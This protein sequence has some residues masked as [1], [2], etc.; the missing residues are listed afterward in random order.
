MVKTGDECVLVPPFARPDGE[1]IEIALN[2]TARLPRLSDMGDSLAYLYVNGITL[3]RVLLEEARH[4]VRQFGASLDKNEIVINI[5]E[6]KPAGDALHSLVQA[7]IGVTCLVQKRRPQTH[8]RFDEE[9]E[10]LIISQGRTYDVDYRIPGA[11]QTH[12]VRFHV[13]SGRR[14]LIQPLT[15][16]NETVAFSWA[17]R[18]AYRFGDI[19]KRDSTWNLFAVLDDRGER[20]SAWT[21]LVLTPLEGLAAIVPWGDSGRL[22][23]ALASSGR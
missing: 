1:Y 3:S 23:E 7:A 16:S 12:L 17:K 20:R 13:D 11:K 6:S 18:W 4:I 14:L 5:D 2:E 15:A 10:S 9:I 19:L 22:S 21:N 8:L